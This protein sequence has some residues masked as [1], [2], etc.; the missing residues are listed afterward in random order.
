MFF[1]VFV[2]IG[3]VMKLPWVFI[4]SNIFWNVVLFSVMKCGNCK[5]L[6]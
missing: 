2:T 6:L 4:G 5:V 3:P 1:L